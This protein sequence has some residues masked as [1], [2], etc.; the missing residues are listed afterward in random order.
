[1]RQKY[2]T[3]HRTHIVKTRLDDDE[4]ELF[5]KQCAAYGISQAEMITQPSC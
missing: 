1:M 2:N 5:Q 4:Y 3:P